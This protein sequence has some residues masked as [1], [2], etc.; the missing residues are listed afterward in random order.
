[1][2]EP[3]AARIIYQVLQGLAHIHGKQI[4]HRD[5]KLDNLIYHE[6]SGALKIIDLG[7]AGSSKDPLK[8]FCGTPSYMSPEIVAKKEYN[9]N[10]ADVWALG[11][12]MYV[13]LTG[14]LPFKSP[15]EKGLYRKI[16]KGTFAVAKNAQD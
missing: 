8:A 4:C 10:G 9:G 1:M 11:V 7:F 3:K 2:P 16:Q 14:F 13:I 12:V 5:I 6:E 15:D